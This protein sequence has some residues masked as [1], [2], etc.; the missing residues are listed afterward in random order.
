MRADSHSSSTF[1]PSSRTISVED[2]AK[3]EGVVQ[4]FE[5]I[6]NSH[7]L[8]ELGKLLTEDAEWVNVVGMWWHGRAEVV[9]AHEIFHATMFRKVNI[10][11][12]GVEIRGIARDV[13]I[14]TVTEQVDNYV[15]P[16]GREMNGVVD[17]LTLALVKTGGEWLI[18]SAHNTT[19]DP[20]AQPH[21][22]ID[23]P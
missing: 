12:T 8:S 1:A 14:A 15:T 11:C 23:H 9:K 13:A 3:I 10:R 21:N 16:D 20:R 6:W 17:R 19:V 22:P 7:R 2:K 4:S 18:A 5:G